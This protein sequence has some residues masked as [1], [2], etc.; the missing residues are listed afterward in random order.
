M[1]SKKVID[2]Y[3]LLA[4]LENAICADKVAFL[5]KNALEKDSPLM[6][7]SLAWCEACFGIF[8]SEDKS[9]AADTI[10]NILTLPIEIVAF[11]C[12][13]AKIAAAI[14]SENKISYPDA[15]SL[16]LAKIKKATLVT[17]KQE[18]REFSK[19]VDIEIL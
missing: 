2:A 18:L 3:S 5:I 8:A 6:I 12:E 4:F 19:I 7:S 14:K 13:A 16:A 10:G 15:A 1:A 17:G 9:K 11:D